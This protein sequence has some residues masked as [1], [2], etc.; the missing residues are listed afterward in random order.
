MHTP[1]QPASA[2]PDANA[3]APITLESIERLF[4]KEFGP[5]HASMKGLE[6]QMTQLGTSVEAANKKADEALEKAIEA[7]QEIA[8]VMTR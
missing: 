4:K 8:E 6:S 3:S 2:G 5:M 7:K 1:S